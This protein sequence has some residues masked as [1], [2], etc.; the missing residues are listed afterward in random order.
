MMCSMMACSMFVLKRGLARQAGR[1]AAEAA[2]HTCA[3]L[4]RPWAVA[5]L[6]LL[7]LPSSAGAA[8]LGRLLRQ[9]NFQEKAGCLHA[10][11]AMSDIAPLLR[12]S[13][14]LLESCHNAKPIVLQ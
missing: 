2:A 1:G 3:K 12:C 5:L 9:A 10:M 7:A 8:D 6:A 14:H 13:H 4:G 11:K